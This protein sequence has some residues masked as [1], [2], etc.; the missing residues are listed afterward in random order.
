VRIFSAR[1]EFFPVS[2]RKP[3]DRRQRRAK[4]RVLVLHPPSTPR[5]RGKGREAAPHWTP[6]TTAA[7]AA[8]WGQ[9]LARAVEPIDVAALRRLFDLYDE[10]ER[11]WAA[12]RKQRFVEGSQGQPV[13]NPAGRYALELEATIE[14]L[15]RAF[16]VTPR[17]RLQLG[18]SWS[19]VQKSLDDLNREANERGAG[20][21]GPDPRLGTAPR[22]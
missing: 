9:P 12:F 14:R 18:I 16:G 1:Q 5:A 22:K 3:P 7:W 20:D 15:E 8:F 17:A 21:E 13:L 4:P 19:S 10:R 11:T 2:E 6:A